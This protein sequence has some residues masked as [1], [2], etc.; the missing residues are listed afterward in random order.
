M[1]VTG[2]L[3]VIP[4]PFSDGVFDAAS[5]SRMLDHMLGSV[6]GYTLLGSTGE[7]PSMTTAERMAIC[8]YALSNTP[9]D[10]RV[11][12]GI[13]HT[14]VAD[15]IELAEHAQSRGAAAVLCAVPYY[16]ENSRNGPLGYLR[17]L[18]AILEVPLVLYDNPVATKTQLDAD[19]VSE[20]ASHLSHLTAVKLTDHDLSKVGA[21][22][23]RG[24]TVLAG[25][26]PIAFRYLEAGV[27]GVM[28]IAPLLCPDAFRAVWDRVREGNVAGAYAVFAEEILPVLH[29]IGIGDEIATTKAILAE[30]GVF[31]SREL[32]V[33]L[34][35]STPERRRLLSIAA[36]IA[37]RATASRLLEASSDAHA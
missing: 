32:R 2:V 4:T 5:F 13:T 7:A 12:V 30:R 17:S 35:P 3:P 31:A 14:S 33:P 11:V 25:D 22:Q 34:E 15:G 16:F 26:D 1:T 29:V 24:L 37:R 23:A 19:Q 21:W 20:W 10:K 28:I 27:D 8:E 18:D 6:D 9:K 36:E